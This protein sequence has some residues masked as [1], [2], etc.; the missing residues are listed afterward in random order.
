MLN[1]LWLQQ[2]KKFLNILYARA[3]VVHKVI[4]QLQPS[5]TARI[6]ASG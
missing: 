6:C 1:I 4:D 3:S 5:L 2:T